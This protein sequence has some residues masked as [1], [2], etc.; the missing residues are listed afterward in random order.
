MSS[1]TSRQHPIVRSF[2]ELARTS[3]P[4]GARVLLDGVHLIRD[5]AAAGLELE[6]VAMAASRSS[7]SEEAQLARAL[8][9]RG[10]R[11]LTVSDQTFAA[12]SPVRT[13]SG[14]IAI[15][16]RC[17]VEADDICRGPGQLVLVAVDVQ[18]PGN[19]GALV[20]AGEAGG[21]SGVLACGGSANPF[22]WKAIR[23]SM[24]S[25]LRVPVAGGLT[26]DDAVRRV[27][28]HE[29]RIVAAVPRGGTDPDQVNWR[30]R[31]AL[32]VGGEGAGLSEQ[33]LAQADQLVT[34]PMERPVES[35]NVAVAGAIL[36]YAARRQRP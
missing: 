27:R 36:V 12:M 32:V 21:V 18:D 15:A 24:G 10:A 6:A 13:P 8:Q 34:I 7:T 35:L 1:I 30:G 31:V 26:V 29:R 16:R 5:A 19:L 23:G 11:V 3:D 2:R 22:S 28:E 14:V 20:R 9:G 25:V 17:P 33:T 4:T